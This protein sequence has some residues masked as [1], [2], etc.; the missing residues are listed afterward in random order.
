MH[1]PTDKVDH[2]THEQACAQA[3]FDN[4]LHIRSSDATMPRSSPIRV[5]SQLKKARQ[6]LQLP[7]GRVSD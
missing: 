7:T 6:E 2:I 4:L 3:T 1:A 5:A